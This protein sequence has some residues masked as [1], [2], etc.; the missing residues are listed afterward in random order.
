M[1][2]KQVR[3]K[4]RCL[5]GRCPRSPAPAQA[6]SALRYLLSRLDARGLRV[7]KPEDPEKPKPKKR[8]WLHWT[9]DA[10]YGPPLRAGDPWW[11]R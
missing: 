6:I 11:E 3:C 10:L 7:P 1:V 9:D 5:F 4:E 2:V 8:P